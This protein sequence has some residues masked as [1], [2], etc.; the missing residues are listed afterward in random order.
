MSLIQCSFQ[1]DASHRHPPGVLQR[2]R[3]SLAIAQWSLQSQTIGSSECPGH[4]IGIALHSTRMLDPEGVKARSLY[5]QESLVVGDSNAG[6]PSS[7]IS[8]MTLVALKWAKEVVASLS[9]LKLVAQVF[10]LF[11]FHQFPPFIIVIFIMWVVRLFPWDK[12]NQKS[13]VVKHLIATSMPS[14]PA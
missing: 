4:L 9:G 13:P 5:A 3:A 7:H 6:N 11:R 12:A 2:K 8:E 10:F 14:S 1:Q